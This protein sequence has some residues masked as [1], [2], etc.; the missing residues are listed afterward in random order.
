MSRRGARNQN[1][2]LRRL[3]MK[4]SGFRLDAACNMNSLSKYTYQYRGI[5]NYR[6]LL[7]YMDEAYLYICYI[8]DRACLLN[9]TGQ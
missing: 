4:S 8:G 9:H 7:K 2:K 1:P 3:G 6:P 5:V